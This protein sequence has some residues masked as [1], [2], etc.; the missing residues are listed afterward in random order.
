MNI[1]KIIF[2]S[3]LLLILIVPSQAFAD[4]VLD[5]IEI[6]QT[7]TEANVH[8]DFLTQ[9]RYLRHFPTKEASRIQIFLEFPEYTTLP[10]QREF[11]SNPGS[12]S[13]PKITV[14]FPD[15]VTNG[16]G[17]SQST[18]SIS[19]KFKKSV[20]FY[21]TPDSTGRGVIIHIPIETPSNPVQPPV[22]QPQPEVT[23]APIVQVP[24]KPEGMKLS[25][26]LVQLMN[27][28][29]SA[30]ASGNYE[31]AIQYLNAVLDI[32]PHEFSQ[33]AQELIGIAREKNG[34]L[35]KAK[36]EY[37]LYL[38][39]YPESDGAKRVRDRLANLEKGAKASG[40]LAAKEKKGIKEVHE[41]TVYGSWNQY[42]YD[43]HSHN[44]NPPPAAN[45]NVH[46]QSTL[47]SG[48]DLTAINR[49]NAF[50]SKVVYRNIQTMDFLPGPNHVNKDR[51]L[52]AYLELQDKDVDY[53]FRVGR[54]NGNSGGVLGRFDGAWLKYGITPSYKVNFVAGALD[55]YNVEYHRYFYGINFDIGQLNAKWSGNVFYVDQQ[56]ESITDRRSVGGELRYFDAGRSVYSLLD[57][58]ILYDQVNIA[59]LQGNM[60]SEGGYNYNILLD[61]RK[62][63]VL[64]LVNSLP[65]YFPLGVNTINQV[66]ERGFANES[67]IRADAQA[68]TLDTDLYLFGVTKQVTPKWQLGGDVRMNRSS[69]TQA[70]GLIATQNA[71][72]AAADA[73][74]PT[75]TFSLTGLPSSVG[76]GN[77]WTYT[78]QAIGTDTLFSN[79][80][81]VISGSYSTG[82]IS[83]IKSLIFSNVVTRDKWRYD[84]SFKYLRVD[85]VP[86]STSD[87]VSPIFRLG[88]RFTEKSTV[89]AEFGVEFVNTDDLT[90][91][92]HSLR[93][94]SF[95]GYRLDF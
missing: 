14:N 32:P 81:S 23:V 64:Q 8:I 90:G 82:Q 94:F 51:T 57:Y 7:Q 44:Y 84:S 10:T 15:Q 68:L 91:H 83:Q 53:L 67:Q 20:K 36:A 25:D 13:L 76:T 42:Y 79:D 92:S 55:E 70:A 72:K 54:Q 37:D 78:V 24:G 74:L 30:M 88:Y 22:V 80:T 65:A 16:N 33:E 41:T 52:A 71:I 93:D 39:L 89:E 19:V 1:F 56:V 40:G 61:H 11:L 26:Y 62:S 69:G 73:G 31:K 58:D 18:G 29:R 3:L 48:I 38:K 50:Q 6:E 28:S 60:Q 86:S 77:I 35:V 75:D 12:D 45:T 85:S 63:P 66:L 47:I 34:D 17:S 43:S 9:V 46:D 59:M 87:V 2:S 95:V 4:K 5:K 49:Q 27:E 21:I